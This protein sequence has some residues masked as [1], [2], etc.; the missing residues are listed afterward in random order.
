MHFQHYYFYVLSTRCPS[1]LLI[2]SFLRAPLP[3]LPSRKLSMESDMTQN[4]RANFLY[5]LLEMAN[6]QYCR[7][8]MSDQRI[9]CRSI[10]IEMPGS[11]GFFCQGHSLAFTSLSHSPTVFDIHL[12]FVSHFISIH[13]HFIYFFISPSTFCYLLIKCVIVANNILDERMAYC[14]RTQQVQM[15]FSAPF[16]LHTLSVPYVHQYDM[17]II[18]CFSYTCFFFA[19]VA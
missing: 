11:Q 1:S 13:L 17:F 7:L 6:Y 9:F 5:K 8:S 2:N 14:L 10:E 19:L 12:P 18:C 16:S 4:H 3:L 15:L